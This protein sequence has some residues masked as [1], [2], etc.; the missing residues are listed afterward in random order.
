MLC[1]AGNVPAGDLLLPDSVI[2]Y[3]RE[4]IQKIK[5]AIPKGIPL[6]IKESAATEKYYN[7]KG[8]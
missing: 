6:D 5:R 4:K 7:S 1:K 2:V 3:T 8:V